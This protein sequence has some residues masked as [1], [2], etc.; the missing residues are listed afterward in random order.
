METVFLLFPECVLMSREA[1]ESQ[2]FSSLFFSQKVLIH[3]FLFMESVDAHLTALLSAKKG[4]W[5]GKK[6]VCCSFYA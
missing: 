2:I 4:G 6:S 1:R 5:R 3:I